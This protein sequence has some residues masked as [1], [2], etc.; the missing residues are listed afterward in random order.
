MDAPVAEEFSKTWSDNTG[1]SGAVKLYLNEIVQLSKDNISS[2]RWAT[3]Q[4]CS[5]ALAEAA[6]ALG[7]YNV[8]LLPNG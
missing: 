4:T 3:K 2:A 7:M 8:P 1:G 5:L 6:K